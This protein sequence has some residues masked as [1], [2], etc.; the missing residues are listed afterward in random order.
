[1]NN[2]T[3]LDVETANCDRSSIC[4]IGMINGDAGYETL[5]NPCVEFD[6]FNVGIHG[7][8]EDAVRDAPKFEDVAPAVAD[9]IGPGGIMASYTGFD[10][11]ALRQ[12]CEQAGIAPLDYVYLDIARVVRRTW[13]EKYGKRGYGLKNVCKDMGIE[14]QHH[15]ALE[16]AKAAAE[17]LRR[18]IEE[19][20]RTVNE[21]VEELTM[22]SGAPRN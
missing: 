11:T 8:D 1:M 6:P 14:F 12:A 19:S 22:P 4:Q 5:I 7:I 21:W 17:I 10:H 18:A 16:D 15:D 13:P 20:G 3:V 9:F 2:V